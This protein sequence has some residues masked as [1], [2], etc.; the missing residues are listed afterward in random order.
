MDVN[1]KFMVVEFSDGLQIVPEVWLN[2]TKKTCIWP[3]H[4]KTQLRINKAIITKE[5]PKEQYEGMWEELPIKRIFGSAGELI[6]S[7]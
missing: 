3:S 1:K 7:R 4:F 6:S 2:I 5:M